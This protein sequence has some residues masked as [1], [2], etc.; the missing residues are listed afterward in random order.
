MVLFVVFTEN[1]AG[2]WLAPVAT[3]TTVT[4]KEVVGP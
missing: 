3:G 4:W 2:E 1:D